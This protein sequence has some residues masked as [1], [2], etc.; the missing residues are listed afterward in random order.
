MS[1]IVSLFTPSSIGFTFLSW[2]L[3][4]LA[5]HTT[6]YSCNDRRYRDLPDNPLTSINAHA[7]AK[8]HPCGFNETR[9]FIL[10][11]QRKSSKHF[12][13]I[14]ASTAPGQ[15]LIDDTPANIAQRYKEVIELECKDSLELT[16]L[17]AATGPFIVSDI[18][19]RNKTYRFSVRT[20]ENKLFCHG[21]YVDEADYRAHMNELFFSKSVNA[22][23]T[24]GLTDAWDIR[25]RTSLNLRI[26][27]N[28]M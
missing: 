10:D 14:Y 8:N 26:H 4:Y 5:G 3:H 28:I 15:Y 9:L 2:S 16:S 24:L 19:P 17:C 6:S 27:P 25:E 1:K 22:Y 12:H 21:S 11:L 23:N 7:F 18:S 20:L 13:T